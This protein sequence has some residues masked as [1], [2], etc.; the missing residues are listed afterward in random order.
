MKTVVLMFLG[1]VSL[2]LM[3]SEETSR[4]CDHSKTIGVGGDRKVMQEIN[5]F[6]AKEI[7][8]VTITETEAIQL[9]KDR[10]NLP[11][12][13]LDI[14]FDSGLGWIMGTVRW[15]KL[16]VNFVVAGKI[17][18]ATVNPQAEI[19]EA[20]VG[21]S[22]LIPGLNK[23]LANLAERQ[24]NQKLSGIFVGYP[25]QVIFEPTQVSLIRQ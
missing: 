18:F 15:L 9:I 11:I 7:D 16:P 12:E 6:L 24:L 20:E 23:L 2:G 8:N 22:R 10:L 19:V 25:Y 5:L 1:L 3:V 17:N 21:R 4:R 14:C 13:N